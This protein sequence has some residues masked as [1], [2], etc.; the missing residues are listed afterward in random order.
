MIMAQDKQLEGTV[1]E[2]SQPIPRQQAPAQNYAQLRAFVAN[3]NA[4]NDLE[5]LRAELLFRNDNPVMAEPAP[6]ALP[7]AAHHLAAPEEDTVDDDAPY[8]R[9][10]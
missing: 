2:N 10:R 7:L 4:G 6:R 3:F 5:E 9:L 1:D 8:R